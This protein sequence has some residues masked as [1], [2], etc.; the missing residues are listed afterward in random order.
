[1]LKD[2]NRVDKKVFKIK[3]EVLAFF[4]QIRDMLMVN[5]QNNWLKIMK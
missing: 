2:K 5:V 4:A 3:C 1:M